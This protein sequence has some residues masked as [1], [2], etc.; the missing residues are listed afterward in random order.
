MRK[1]GRFEARGTEF[2]FDPT[3]ENKNSRTLETK[4]TNGITGPLAN[5]PR[6]ADSPHTT[7][8]NS[9]ERFRLMSAQ[10]RLPK[11]PDP[12]LLNGASTKAL[13]P[14]R[15]ITECQKPQEP[16][17]PEG[18]SR[19]RVFAG[20]WGAKLPPLPPLSLYAQWETGLKEF[21]VDPKRVVTPEDT[22]DSLTAQMLISDLRS[23]L[24]KAK[25][26][27]IDSRNVRTI[28]NQALNAVKNSPSK[29]T[30][31]IETLAKQLRLKLDEYEHQGWEEC[32]A[33]Q[34][35]SAFIKTTIR[36]RFWSDK[37]RDRHCFP[38]GEH[39]AR[40]A[41]LTP[42]EGIRRTPPVHVL[43]TISTKTGIKAKRDGALNWVTRPAGKYKRK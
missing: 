8:P 29:F 15:P 21:K 20:E 1:A 17:K 43:P 18:S 9:I 4:P 5:A 31:E 37:E 13:K 6:N 23:N 16:L 35:F 26:N 40:R 24:H 7:A 30:G 33:P 36:E 11:L 14:T 22:V 41:D 34:G 32:K 2:T 38:I 28:L 12:P 3:R 42:G 39:R 25:T 27:R 19:A 10:N